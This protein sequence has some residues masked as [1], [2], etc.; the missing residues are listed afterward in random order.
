MI[1]IKEQIYSVVNHIATGITGHSDTI[2]GDIHFCIIRNEARV[3]SHNAFIRNKT[4]RSTAA[5]CYISRGMRAD[6]FV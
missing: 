5:C 3:N 2:T 4:D 6:F 1:I